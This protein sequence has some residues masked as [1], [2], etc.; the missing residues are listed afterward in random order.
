MSGVYDLGY[1]GNRD[2]SMPLLI[3]QYNYILLSVILASVQQLSVVNGTDLK[4]V[5]FSY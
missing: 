2:F 1:S 5:V 3:Y 4:Y